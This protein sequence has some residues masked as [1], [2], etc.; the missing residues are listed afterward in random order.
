MA[1]FQAALDHVLQFEGGYVDD[2]DD[3]GGRTK[4]GIS[5]EAHPE[6]WKDGPPTEEQ[7]MAIYRSDYWDHQRIQAGKIA[8]DRI[9]RYLFDGAVNHGP[10]TAARLLQKAISRCGPDIAVDGWVGPETRQALRSVDAMTALDRF[11]LARVDF[12]RR[13]VDS[14]GSQEKFLFGWLNRALDVVEL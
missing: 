4:F 2:P 3:R 5:E 11:V 6:A 14:D 8:D 12:Y 1:D 13:L 7:A 9:A 10:E